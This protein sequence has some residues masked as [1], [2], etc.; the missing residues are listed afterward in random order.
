MKTSDSKM[1]KSDEI[2]EYVDSIASWELAD[3]KELARSLIEK[4]GD[5]ELK[6][7]GRITIESL[8]E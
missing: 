4:I 8:K 6:E 1:S 3:Q 2:R 5:E 7:F